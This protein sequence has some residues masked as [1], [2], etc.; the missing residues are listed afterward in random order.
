MSTSQEPLYSMK[1]ALQI[2]PILLLLN[3][4]STKEKN[5]ESSQV[6]LPNGTYLL[7][8]KTSGDTLRFNKKKIKKGDWNYKIWEITNDSI[9]Q[10]DGRGISHFF[11]KDRRR[12]ILHDD[13]LYIWT[14]SKNEKGEANKNQ[15]ESIEKYL[16]LR[17]DEK[18]LELIDLNKNKV[19]ETTHEIESDIQL[20]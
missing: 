8:D 14:N 9:F 19:I 11:E 2:L 12:Y 18:Q 16:V 13:T 6:Y 17:S 10:K 4:C 1:K 3:S 15:Q 5:N 7:K 20:R